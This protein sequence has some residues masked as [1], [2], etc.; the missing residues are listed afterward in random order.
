MP[1]S[2]RKAQE[3]RSGERSTDRGRDMN[4]PPVTPS[5]RSTVRHPVGLRPAACLV[6]R[7]RR[8]VRITAT[9]VGEWVCVVDGADELGP[10][11]AQGVP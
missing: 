7:W 5:G 3:H 9:R 8:I 4:F 10:P 1:L 11:K 2:P 6:A